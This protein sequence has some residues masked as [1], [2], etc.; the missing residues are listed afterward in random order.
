MACCNYSL[1]PTILNECRKLQKKE[2]YFTLELTETVC[3]CITSSADT[4]GYVLFTCT[5]TKEAHLK[6]AIPGDSLFQFDFFALSVEAFKN[7]ASKVC[8]LLQ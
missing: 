1:S 5:K 7:F 3:T 2:R 8:I 6:T 4:S